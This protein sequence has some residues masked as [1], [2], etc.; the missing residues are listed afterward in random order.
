MKDVHPVSVVEGESYKV[1][2]K[3]LNQPIRIGCAFPKNSN[4]VIRELAQ[5]LLLDIHCLYLGLTVHFITST[6]LY[7]TTLYL[8]TRSYR[9]AHKGIHQSACSP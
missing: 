3:L 5:W 7:Y 6:S 1:I 8:D 4:E 9:M 2:C